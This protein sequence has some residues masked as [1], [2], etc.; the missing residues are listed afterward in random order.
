MDSW[1]HIQR[2][3]YIGS[4]TQNKGIP[5]TNIFCWIFHF[6]KIRHHNE[7]VAL[8]LLNNCYTLVQQS[9]FIVWSD[10]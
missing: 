2:F 6:V 1:I 8:S 4:K 7:I 5:L 10:S 9:D 3:M